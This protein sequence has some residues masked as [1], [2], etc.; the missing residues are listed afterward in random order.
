[1]A[2]IT[3]HGGPSDKTLPA[4]PEIAGEE[5]VE[6]ALVEPTVESAE[7]KP[8]DEWTLNE[9]QVECAARGLAKSGNKA[10]LVLRL[11]EDDQEQ[12]AETTDEEVSPVF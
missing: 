10:D 6:A 12:P 7:A 4:A 8:Y 5:T 11:E 9:L 2:K 1:M 3:V